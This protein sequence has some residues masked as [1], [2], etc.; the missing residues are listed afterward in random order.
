MQPCQG[1]AV[2]FYAKAKALYMNAISYHWLRF[3]YNTTAQPK[4]LNLCNAFYGQVF[5]E[6]SRVL[7][8]L[9]MKA[10]SKKKWSI[11]TLL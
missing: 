9:C 3:V 8:W 1:D 10:I 5:R 4:F 6:P 2:C 11:L 7:G